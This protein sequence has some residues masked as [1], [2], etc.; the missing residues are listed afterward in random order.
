MAENQLVPFLQTCLN[1]LREGLLG[2]GR[3]SRAWGGL[4][5]VK[6]AQK[7]GAIYSDLGQVDPML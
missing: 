4:S 5:A 3:E 6:G 2:E 7:R 1:K